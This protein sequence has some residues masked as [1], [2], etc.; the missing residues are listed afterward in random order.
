MRQWW[1]CWRIIWSILCDAYLLW[2]T[3]KLTTPNQR[4]WGCAHQWDFTSR[5]RSMLLHISNTSIFRNL[6]PFPVWTS[7]R[8]CGWPTSGDQ[9]VCMRS[10]WCRGER[11]RNPWVLLFVIIGTE[12]IFQRVRSIYFDI[13][14][15]RNDIR[16]R[17]CRPKIVLEVPEPELLKSVIWSWST[18]GP[19]E[20]HAYKW[21][22]IECAFNIH[23]VDCSYYI[24]K[25]WIWALTL[26]FNVR[27]NDMILDVIW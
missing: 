2:T 1:D 21:S 15:V 12:I 26:I 27:L 22:D 16:S 10:P 20:E 5:W 23:H 3:H 9:C 14:V 18:R 4:R 11:A 13:G 8:P 17:R 24:E 25:H 7:K 19:G 6:L